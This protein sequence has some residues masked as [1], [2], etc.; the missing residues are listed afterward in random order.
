M[1]YPS[2]PVAAVIEHLI[3]ENR[4]ASEKWEVKGIIPDPGTA[5]ATGRVIH[6]S[7]KATQYLFGGLEL[8]VSRSEAEN[9]Y[10]NLSSPAPKVFV[11]WRMQNDVAVPVLAT[12]SYGEG[13]RYLDSGEQVD[14]VAMPPEIIAWLGAYV[15]DNYRPEPKLPRKRRKARE[16]AA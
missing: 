16:G 12:V 9:Y 5:P 10:L 3:L 13:A 1:S 6:R 7:A 15:E 14:G 4:W 8:A 2:F 11:M